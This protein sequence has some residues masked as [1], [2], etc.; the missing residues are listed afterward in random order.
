MMTVSLDHEKKDSLEFLKTQA[1]RFQALW[2]KD[3]RWMKLL[4]FDSIPYLIVLN[5]DGKLVRTLKGFNSKT[6]A[7]FTQLIEEK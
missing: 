4:D 7:V 5:G 3:K 2:D 6:R 1:S